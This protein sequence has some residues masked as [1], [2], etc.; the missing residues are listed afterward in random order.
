ME[1]KPNRPAS[2]HYFDAEPGVASRPGSIDLVLPDVRLRLATDTG[3]FA[4]SAVDPGTKYLLLDGPAPPAGARNLLDLGCGYGPIALTLARRAPDAT[5]WAVDVNERARALCAANAEEAGLTNVR[6]AAPD[7]VPD[8]TA[9]DGMWSNPPIRIG[10]AALH[11]LLTRWLAKLAPDAHAALVV[12]KHL[13]SDSLARW[14]G[15]QGW[16]VV[17]LGSR[18]GYRILDV[19]KATP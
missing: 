8:A 1:A 14:L 12:Q 2:T 17:R 9:F 15:E 3:V 19:T 10:K 11:D 18:R 4:G 13:G 7:D 6:V 5:V 16:T